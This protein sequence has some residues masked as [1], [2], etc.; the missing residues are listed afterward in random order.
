MV[1]LD[2][3]VKAYTPGDAAVLRAWIEAGGAMVVMSGYTGGASD[4]DFPNSLLGTLNLRLLNALRSGPVVSFIPHAT[5][6]SITSMTFQGGYNVAAV[7]SSTTSTA[8]IEVARLPSGPVGIA[9]IRGEGRVFLWGD[10][11]IEFDSEWSSLP[12]VPRFWANILSW[13]TRQR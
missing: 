11:W 8:S 6:T 9:A 5:T 12:L 1:I 13:V 10:E 7:G 2:R 4:Y 3:L